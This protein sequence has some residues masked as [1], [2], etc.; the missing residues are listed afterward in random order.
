[1]ALVVPLEHVLVRYETKHSDGLIQY[2]IYF[3][4]GFLFG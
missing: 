1:M 4:I 3:V 2:N